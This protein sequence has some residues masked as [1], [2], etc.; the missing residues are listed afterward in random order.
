MDYYNA[1]PDTKLGAKI[2]YWLANLDKRVND[3]LFFSLGDY[4]LMACMERYP[5]DP[6][7]KECYE[8]YMDDLEINYLG[9]DKDFPPEIKT[10]VKKLQKL[11]DYQEEE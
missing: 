10:R 3:D 7:A 1:H 5:K 11:I 4:Y 6:I 2:L 9:K 8:S